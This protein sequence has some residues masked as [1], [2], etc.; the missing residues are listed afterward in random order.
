VSCWSVSSFISINEREDWSGSIYARPHLLPCSTVVEVA[1]CV[2]MGRKRK[3]VTAKRDVSWKWEAAVH[4]FSGMNTSHGTC[5]IIMENVRLYHGWT[6]NHPVQDSKWHDSSV[7]NCLTLYWSRPGPEVSVAV[8]L[9]AQN[10]CTL[11][12]TIRDIQIKGQR[13]M[14]I[15]LVECETQFSQ[16][17]SE[18][19]TATH[20]LSDF[21][22]GSMN[23]EHTQFKFQ[24]G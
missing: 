17:R 23:Q 15:K 18:H 8:V 13:E 7:E 20:K 16:H 11:C 1:G 5:S 4:Y 3:L 9:L 24:E 19:W 10:F 2:F 6:I 21:L 12:R 22:A 14:K